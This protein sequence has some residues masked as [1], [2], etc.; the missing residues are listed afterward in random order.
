MRRTQATRAPT[1]RPWLRP[2]VAIL[3]VAPFLGEVM[4]TS[5]PPLDLLLP[6]ILALQ[7]ALYGCGALLCRE[8]ARRL[9]LGLPGLILL[10]AAYAVYEEALITGFW[11]DGSYQDE[12]G[13]GAYSRVWQIN[14]LVAGHLTAYHVAVS[15][16]SS[17]LLV[18]RLFPAYRER[19]CAGR[20]GL[21]VAA[22]GLFVLLPLGYG[23]SWQGPTGQLIAAVALVALLIGAALLVP[24]GS[25]PARPR[26]R[27]PRF[28]GSVAFAGTGAHFLLTY[29]V[30]STG[31]PWPV[32]TAIALAPIAAAFLLI[33]PMTAAGDTYGPVGLRIVTGVL[34][35][36][37]LLDAAVGLAGR[38]DL[39]VA[40][41][42]TAFAL[43]RLSRRS[44]LAVTPAARPARNRPARGSPGLTT[45][46]STW[47]DRTTPA[48]LG[49]PYQC[50]RQELPWPGC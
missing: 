6:W 5:T 23:D 40:A 37:V 27:R 48:R 25:P 38:Y 9:R 21:T 19:A 12:V 4:S 10:A 20:R 50:R 22:V 3:L 30:P 14:L 15:I 39:T 18:E 1:G 16:G 17:I 8:V 2:G 47:Y 49:R 32:G 35:F 42:L 26:R 7:A 11:F 33:R 41:L 46:S 36:F 44:P 29:T 28:V 43:W 24:R 31:P 13:I 34:S 45:V